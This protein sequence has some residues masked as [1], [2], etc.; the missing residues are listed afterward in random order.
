MYFLCEQ[1]LVP[2]QRWIVVAVDIVITY[3]STLT[4]REYPGNSTYIKIKVFLHQEHDIP[5]MANSVKIF[6]N[7]FLAH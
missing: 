5:I 1:S 6:I 4:A 2:Q 7:I 3:V